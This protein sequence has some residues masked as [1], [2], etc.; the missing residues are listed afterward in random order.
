MSD[1][2]TKIAPPRL[3][4]GT[5]LKNLQ[6]LAITNASQVLAV[7]SQVRVRWARIFVTVDC[8]FYFR[9]DNAG[10]VD[11]TLTTAQGSNSTTIGYQMKANTFQDFELGGQDNFI[12]IQGTGNGIA[13]I[14]GVGP[15]GK[16]GG[17][18]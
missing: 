8:A 2:D 7:D 1:K 17:L 13:Q 9:K 11:Q 18:P 5:A 12:V 4:P 10:S 14:L 15:V 6:Q 3:D 16:S